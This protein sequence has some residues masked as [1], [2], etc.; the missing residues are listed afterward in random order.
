MSPRETRINVLRYIQAMISSWGKAGSSWS[1][2]YPKV[3]IIWF[4]FLGPRVMI[5]SSFCNHLF[6]RD[7]FQTHPGC[8][9]EGR[10]KLWTLL[11][12]IAYNNMNKSKVKE[13]LWKGKTRGENENIESNVGIH[14]QKKKRKAVKMNRSKVNWN[15]IQKR[16]HCLFPQKNSLLG[17]LSFGNSGLENG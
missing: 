11:H 2:T 16:F 17:A 1:S 9:S 13:T 15:S 5:I 7:W 3:G 4:H 10:L 12:F 14:W 6:N 8:F